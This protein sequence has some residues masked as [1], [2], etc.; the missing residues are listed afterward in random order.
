MNQGPKKEEKTKLKTNNINE[1]ITKKEKKLRLI[2]TILYNQT[3]DKKKNK[4]LKIFFLI[5]IIK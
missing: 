3:E 4:K 1:K 2:T 5:K